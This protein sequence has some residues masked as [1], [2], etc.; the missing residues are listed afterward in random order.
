MKQAIK[1]AV[2]AIPVYALA[3]GNAMA[4]AIDVSGV[5]T[6]IEAQIPSIVSIGGAVLLVIVALVAFSWVRRSIRG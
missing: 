4:A 1:A 2:V 6:D 5:V 3:A